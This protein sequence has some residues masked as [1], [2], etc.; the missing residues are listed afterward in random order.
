M[1]DTTD[2]YTHRI[3]RT[4]RAAKTGDAFTFITREDDPMV[5][6]IERVLGEKVERRTLEGFNYK[7]PAPSCSTGT[8]RPPR[9]PHHGRGKKKKTMAWTN[10]AALS[11]KSGR[12][13]KPVR[14]TAV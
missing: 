5:R 8:A 2:A 7:K 3:G 1:P 6:S 12:K 14:K 4:G 13:S 9:G 11:H 10:A